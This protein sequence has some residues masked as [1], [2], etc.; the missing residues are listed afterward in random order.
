MVNLPLEFGQ[1]TQSHWI[2]LKQIRQIGMNTKSQKE[3]AKIERSWSSF[4]VA[5]RTRKMPRD[6]QLIQTFTNSIGPFN[7]GGTQLSELPWRIA[8]MSQQRG[9][10][11]QLSRTHTP[12]KERSH[13]PHSTSCRAP[14]A[15]LGHTLPVGANDSDAVKIVREVVDHTFTAFT[16]LSYSSRQAL[17]MI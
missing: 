2:G 17:R 16:A 14:S 11:P 15:G 5:G 7:F 1:V 4:A 6:T 3:R 8:T 9:S 10:V 12:A 13:C